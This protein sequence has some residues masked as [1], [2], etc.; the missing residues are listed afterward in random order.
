MERHAA[1]NRPSGGAPL[2]PSGGAEVGAT[3]ADRSPL[4]LCPSHARIAAV[5]AGGR[6]RPGAGPSHC[7]R[8]GSGC[9]E[10]RQYGAGRAHLFRRSATVAHDRVVCA[11]GIR[12]SGME[13]AHD[14]RPAGNA[15]LASPSGANRRLARPAAWANATNMAPPDRG[16]APATP[17][18]AP[19]RASTLTGQRSLQ[20]QRAAQLSGPSL[21][22]L[23]F[24]GASEFWQLIAVQR[25][26]AGGTS[27]QTP[28]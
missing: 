5:Q 2:G 18:S 7:R 21:C 1:G 26:R 28:S 6:L 4:R 11:L 15:D 3:G 20:R 8:L 19:S 9:S 14:C 22:Q 16:G 24:E 27:V 12:V 25:L 13:A 10:N 17:A 23:D